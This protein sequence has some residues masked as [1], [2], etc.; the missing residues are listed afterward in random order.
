[1][2]AKRKV[3]R[4]KRDF[5]CRDRRESNLLEGSQEM[6]ARPSDN[7]RILKQV[8]IYLP[9]AKAIKNE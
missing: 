9:L 8:V 3:M 2:E 4:A 6:P 1:V 5:I 7:D